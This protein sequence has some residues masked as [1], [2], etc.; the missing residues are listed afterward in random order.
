VAD[1]GWDGARASAAA[2]EADGLACRRA[3]QT[4]RSSPSSAKA[5][6]PISATMR[7]PSPS[8][9]R[10]G[11]TAICMSL[12]LL[13]S[14]TPGSSVPHATTRGPGTGPPPGPGRLPPR[15]A[16]G[17]AAAAGGCPGRT[18]R[19][20]VP[21]RARQPRQ[22]DP[23]R[24]AGSDEWRGE[25]AQTWLRGRGPLPWT[26]GDQPEGRGSRKMYLAC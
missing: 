9:W 22:P 11:S 5:L 8:P 26:E 6:S 19:T 24:P 23:S 18:F 3:S 7:R 12:P 2:F 1:N 13:A 20:P 21:R 25:D 10:C 16:A 14:G 15:S 4:S 17:R